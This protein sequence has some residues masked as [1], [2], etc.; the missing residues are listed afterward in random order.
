MRSTW[1]PCIPDSKCTEKKFYCLPKCIKIPIPSLVVTFKQCE[2]YE[3]APHRR[4]NP[5]TNDTCATDSRECISNLLTLVIRVCTSC[6][7]ECFQVFSDWSAT[8]RTGGK[9]LLPQAGDFCIQS[10]P[11]ESNK[12]Y[13]NGVRNLDSKSLLV[14][15][16]TLERGDYV[17]TVSTVVDSSVD[18][19]FVTGTV[20]GIID[21]QPFQLGYQVDLCAPFT[22]CGGCCE[23]DSCS[24]HK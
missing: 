4:C 21:C 9:P 24:R 11:L 17:L 14:C 20:T 5:C 23:S 18:V 16:Q 15:A 10:L 22:N 3:V 8:L 2:R 19:G 13:F 7:I 1:Q 12:D 6:P